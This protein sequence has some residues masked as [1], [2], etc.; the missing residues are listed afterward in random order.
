MPSTSLDSLERA[1]LQPHPIDQFNLWFQQAELKEP[2]LPNAM[3]LS[4]VNLQYEVSARMVLLKSFDKKGFVF[5]TNYNSA[6]AK[7][8]SEVPNA[9]LVFWWPHCD[10]QIRI[11]GK[12][13]ILEP[14]LS[15][16]YFA[17]RDKWARLGA[18]VSKQSEVIES[19]EEMLKK[20][21]LLEEQHVDE[22]TIVRPKNWGG[23][24]LVPNRIEF[25]QERD[26]RLHDRFEY[27][28]KGE[29]WEIVR[30]AP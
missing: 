21:K 14:H 18:L 25:W 19:R 24:R 28:K 11:A 12:V 16:E 7:C 17:T 10:R 3:C 20:I 2:L 4:T 27:R 30:L 8:L 5:Y 15:D 23:Y 26:H 9:A 13:E 1:D 29:D 22:K 6:K